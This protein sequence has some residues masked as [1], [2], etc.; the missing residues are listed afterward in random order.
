MRAAVVTS[1]GRPPRY[2][3]AA[4]PRPAPGEVVLDVVAAGLHPVVRALASGAHYASDGSWPHVPGIDG[5][6]RRPDGTLVHFSGLAPG[7]GSMAERVA[8]PEAALVPLPEAP[9]GTPPG[10]CDPVQIAA[11]VNPALSAWLALR[12]R[13][14]LRPGENVLVLGAT[15]CAGRMAVRLAHLA[16]AADIA[17]A[18]RD[19]TALGELPALGAT[20]TVALDGGTEDD[21]PDDGSRADGD[22]EDGGTALAE[23]AARADVV[24]DYLWGPVTERALAAVLRRRDRARSGRSLRWVQVGDAAGPDITLP[25]RALRQRDLELLGSGIGSVAPEAVRGA[26][27]ELI[28]TLPETGLRV[29]AQAVPLDGIERAWPLRRSG[30]RVVLVP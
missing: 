5:V 26:T 12:L 13:A 8:A 2:G 16:G 18:G 29:A 20:R 15:G 7:R 9:P 25:A 3:T 14:C 11:L 19:R 6:G 30:T 27:R 10:I 4:E 28:S 24:V 21:A 17:A 22:P 1:P 23:A